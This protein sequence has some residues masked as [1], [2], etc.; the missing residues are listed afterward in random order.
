MDNINISD[1]VSRLASD[2]DSVRKMAVFK[3]QSVIGDPS[4]ADLFINEGGLPRLTT[5]TLQANGNTLAYAL[6]SFS[7]LLEL[8]KGW[9]NVSQ[10]LIERVSLHVESH[11]MPQPFL[12]TTWNI[13]GRPA[14]CHPA[15]GEHSSQRSLG[16]G[17]H[18]LPPAHALQ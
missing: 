5:L 7:R 8:D 13:P 14:H 3:L 6:T 2:E 15:L 9:D 17:C 11:P 1:L 18:C 12:L 16:S 10:E 4:F